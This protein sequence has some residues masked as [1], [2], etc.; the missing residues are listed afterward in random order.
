[1][2]EGDVEGMSELE[3]MAWATERLMKIGMEERKRFIGVEQA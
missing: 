1:M 3:R 2:A